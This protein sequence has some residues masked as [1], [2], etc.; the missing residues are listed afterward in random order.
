MTPTPIITFQGAHGAAIAF[1]RR[2][3]PYG[4]PAVIVAPGAFVW[5]GRDHAWC[6]PLGCYVATHAAWALGVEPTIA[7]VAREAFDPVPG[8]TAVEQFDAMTEAA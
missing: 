8:M 4:S 5:A 6:E 7:M 1:G 2:L 3:V